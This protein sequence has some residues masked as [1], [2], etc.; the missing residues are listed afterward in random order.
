MLQGILPDKYF[1]HALLLSKA[2]RVLLSD[3]ISLSDCS[4]A[5]RLLCLFWELNEQLY[6]IKIYDL[7]AFEVD[8]R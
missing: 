6:G 3:S 8:Y 1:A 5:E 2:I 7:N 4:V